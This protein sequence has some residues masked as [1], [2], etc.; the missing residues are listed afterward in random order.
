MGLQHQLF[1]KQ[2]PKIDLHRHLE[3]SIRLATLLEVRRAHGMPL[4]GTGRLNDLVQVGQDD[5]FTSQNFLSKFQILRQFYKTPEIIS[6]ITEEAVADA[7]SDN[8][9]YLE[10]RFTPAALCRT[11]NFP[12]SDAMDWVI[13]AV[14]SA[15]KKFKVTTRLI[16]S[17]N[18]HESLDLAREVV[19]LAADRMEQGIVG[20]DLAGDEANF[21]GLEFAGIL[22][23]AKRTG[24]HL[25]IHAGEWAGAE[26]VRNAILHLHAERIG[27]GTRVIEDP[28]VI[29]LARNKKITFESCLTSNIQSG[30]VTNASLHPLPK[31]IS[32][33][34]QTTINTDDPSIC[35]TTLGEEFRFAYEILGLSWNELKNQI[36]AAARAAFL[37]EDLKKDLADSL[38]QELF[39]FQPGTVKQN[40][41]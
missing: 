10:L 16:V 26:S 17:V 5:P 30:A 38:A 22:S 2:I 35:R 4:P 13:E 18:R 28:E 1:F 21:S 24:L 36:L 6:R 7:A 23:E 39:S 31:M 25:T 33:G 3:G 15:E 41:S 40:A 8:I 9:R 34:I 20:M 32:S 37:P 12:L 29:E 27:H 19:R 14:Q 11:E